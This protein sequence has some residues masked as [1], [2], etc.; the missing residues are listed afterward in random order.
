M[1]VEQRET[2]VGIDRAARDPQIG[3]D[4]AGHLQVPFERIRRVD[5]D[6][7]TRLDGSMIER[8]A[9][10]EILVR[11]RLFR[12]IDVPIR[13]LP[14]GGRRRGDAAVAAGAVGAA[15]ASEV[16]R[17]VPNPRRRPLLF[18]APDVLPHDKDLHRRPVVDLVSDPLQPP[19]VPAEDRAEVVER[20]VDA[21][22]ELSDA[23]LVLV[24]IAMIPG[25]EDQPLAASGLLGGGP[26]THPVEVGDR[27]QRAVVVVE[28][29]RK[30]ER[31]HGDP[32]VRSLHIREFPEGTVVRMP[33]PLVIPRRDILE[34]REAGERHVALPLPFLLA[35]PGAR[36]AVGLRTGQSASPSFVRGDVRLDPGNPGVIE[37]PAVMEE[38]TCRREGHGREHRL[39]GG[40]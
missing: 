14:F 13:R 12:I 36:I 17:L 6:I 7:L 35:P 28:P 23:R 32:S 11:D 27:P 3:R 25:T 10:L 26:F 37:R 31:R 34:E 21:K 15:G 8:T 5:E 39:Q 1:N 4:R 22:I 9:R 2:E 30:I 19:I 29:A 18:G 24:W 38:V 40:W 16:V 33:Q 20:R